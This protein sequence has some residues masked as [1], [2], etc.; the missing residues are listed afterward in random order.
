MA[1]RRT[2]NS[3]RSLGPARRAKRQSV[4]SSY[5]WYAQKRR[6]QLIDKDGYLIDEDGNLILDENGNK[7]FVGP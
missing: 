2:G 1:R 6:K 7:I 5:N 4:I 3:K